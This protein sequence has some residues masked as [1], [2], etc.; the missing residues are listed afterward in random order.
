MADCRQHAAHAGREFGVLDVEFDID[1]KLTPMAVLT[2]VI[3]AF[4]LGLPHSRQHSFRAQF[5]IFRRMAAGTG[6]FSLVAAGGIDGE[7]LT[8]QCRS[9]LCMLLRIAISTASRSRGRSGQNQA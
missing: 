3:R 6:P 4:T 9:G 1:R 2:Q 8:Q 5:Q 7:Q